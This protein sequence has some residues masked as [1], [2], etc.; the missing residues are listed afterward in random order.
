MVGT[1]ALAINNWPLPAI[2]G[3]YVD[4]MG[5]VRRITV[6]HPLGAEF[7][8]HHPERLMSEANRPK[9]RSPDFTA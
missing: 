5:K 3:D 1:E 9:M 8:G 7:A 6:D 2:A 4:A